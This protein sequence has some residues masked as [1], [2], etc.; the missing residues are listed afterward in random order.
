M[1]PDTTGAASALLIGA[2]AAATRL[3]EQAT[4]SPTMI[5]TPEVIAAAAGGLIGGWLLA[6]VTNIR[7]PIDFGASVVLSGGIGA[8]TGPALARWA[9]TKVSGLTMADPFVAACA[10]AGVGMLLP[11]LFAV[12]VAVL[13]VARDNPAGIGDF[14]RKLINRK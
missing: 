10:G 9:E 12:V 3:V 2:A 14:I 11:P 13:A 4:L 1:H 7:D 5:S 6:A 8:F